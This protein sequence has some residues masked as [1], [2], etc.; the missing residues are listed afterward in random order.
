MLV[1]GAV[2]V[3]T[4]EVFVVDVPVARTVGGTVVVTVGGA[5]V[6]VGVI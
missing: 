5:V 1:P 3:A 4:A 6:T 2:V